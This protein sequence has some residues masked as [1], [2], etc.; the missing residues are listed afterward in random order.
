MRLLKGSILAVLLTVLLCSCAGGADKSAM[1]PS[2]TDKSIHDLATHIYARAEL[3]EIAGFNGSVD[4][5]DAAY[6]IECVRVFGDRFRI[7]YRGEHD[8][9]ELIF[10]ESGNKLFGQV[11]ELALKKQNFDRFHDGGTLD[12]VQNLSPNGVY[13]FLE[14]GRQEPRISY[15]YT[16]DGYLIAIEY[17]ESNRIVKMHTELI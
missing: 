16:S 12:D 17:D 4:Q 1:K 5:L 15:H 6:P 14:T 9:A 3:N 7:S 8:I 10:D 11:R 13:L 2:P